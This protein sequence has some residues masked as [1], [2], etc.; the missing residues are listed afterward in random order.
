MKRTNTCSLLSQNY[1]ILLINIIQNRIGRKYRLKIPIVQT[2]SYRTL[3]K[4]CQAGWRRSHFI[5]RYINKPLILLIISN[6]LFSPLLENTYA[7]CFI[8]NLVAEAVGIFPIQLRCHKQ[9]PFCVGMGTHKRLQA[10]IFICFSIQKLSLPIGT[11]NNIPR[12][13]S[14]CVKHRC[15]QKQFV[16]SLSEGS[17]ALIPVPSRFSITPLYSLTSD[18]KQHLSYYILL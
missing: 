14:S 15:P 16:Y 7:P 4:T 13:F 12:L 11:N 8:W 9:N 6:M 18:W 10:Q 17:M 5:C 2:A 1:S 3:E